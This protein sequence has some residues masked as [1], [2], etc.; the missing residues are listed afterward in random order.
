MSS[1]PRGERGKR[2]RQTG[3][4]EREKEKTFSF[5]EMIQ[6]LSN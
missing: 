3:L 1:G 4:K 6:T 2:K 5:S